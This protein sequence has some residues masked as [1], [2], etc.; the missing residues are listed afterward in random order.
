MTPALTMVTPS[1]KVGPVRNSVL[2]QSPQKCDVTVLP[3]VSPVF[4]TVRGVPAVTL[5]PAPEGTRRFVLY[6]VPEILRQSRQ[7]QMIWDFV[8][9]GY[10]LFSM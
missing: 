7:W 4:A 8:L 1:P 2:P 9:F 10:L 6:V 3:V 5:N